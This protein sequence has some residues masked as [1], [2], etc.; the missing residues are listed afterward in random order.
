MATVSRLLTYDPFFLQKGPG[1]PDPIFYSAADFTRYTAGIMRRSGVLGS[2]DFLVVQADNV[3][4][5]IKVNSGYANVG[6]KYLVHLADDV[7]IDLG[8]TGNPSATRTHKVFLSIYNPLEKDASDYGAAIDVVEDTGAG[9]APPVAAAYYLQLATI[10]VAPNQ[11]NIQNA[12]IDNTVRH[13]GNAG[14]YV[15]LA[16]YLDGAFVP[17]GADTGGVDVRARYENGRVW[18]SGAIK[19]SP[20]NQFANGGSYDIGA[21]HSNLRP[22]HTVYLT[23]AC[24]IY[25]SPSD[26][27]GTYTWRLSIGADGLM[28]ARLPTGTGPLYL[29]FDGMSY[30]LD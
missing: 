17:A 12:N 11:G 22:A 1:D 5:S 25:D 8:F 27:T 13:G 23:G 29:F 21:M 9:A 7:T 30:D 24:S 15:Y 4:M 16:P 19:R 28:N 18:L 26:S 3:G 20:A 14:E 10:T 6:G 2:S